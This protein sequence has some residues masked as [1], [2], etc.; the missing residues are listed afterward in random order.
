LFLLPLFLSL[1]VSAS[2]FYYYYGI[3]KATT[4]D[5]VLS[6]F[7]GSKT[8]YNAGAYSFQSWSVVGCPVHSDSGDPP[9]WYDCQ[10]REYFYTGGTDDLLST[11]K[12]IRIK[13]LP[14]TA[15][16]IA[17]SSHACY[18]APEPE[19]PE[20]GT[21]YS[22][23]IFPSDGVNSGAFDADGC[24]LVPVYK[25]TYCDYPGAEDQ[26]C[27]K[28]DGY[29]YG[30][31][32]P[33]PPKPC[34]TESGKY[35]GEV[36]HNVNCP[37][38]PETKCYNPDGTLAYIADSA[39][40]CP[41]N[42]FPDN[43]PDAPEPTD[44]GDSGGDTGTGGDTGSGDGGDTG[45]GDGGDTGGTGDGSTGG[46]TGGSGTGDGSGEDTDPPGVTGGLTCDKEPECNGDPLTCYQIKQNWRN[47]CGKNEFLQGTNCGDKFLCQGNPTE[48]YRIRLER[49][50]YCSAAETVASFEPGKFQS[51]FESAVGLTESE[52]INE[53]GEIRGL[54]QSADLADSGLGD[55]DLSGGGS[56]GSCPAP[57]PMPFGA[58]LSFQPLCDVAEIIRYLVIGGT[59]LYCLFIINSGVLQGRR[60]S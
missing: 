38:S 14:C 60:K 1:Q 54:W 37:S 22:G 58:E 25:P 39:S 20:N 18:L 24:S 50:H 12:E 46:N 27:T 56:A 57:I 28:F 31:S 2:D 23:E 29:A 49:D 59:A 5:A 21:L 35:I 48:C 6:S 42:T 15:D 7:V 53:E 51:D 40:D 41:A 33:E 9:L 34:Y 3:H 11:I 44:P 45:N 36:S 4:P 43:S 19:C 8:P 47:D 52:M 26:E 55:I 13:R 17:D 10:Y 30:N 32:D 16:Q